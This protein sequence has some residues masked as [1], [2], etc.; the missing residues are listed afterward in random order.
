MIDIL[1]EKILD[2]LT[3]GFSDIEDLLDDINEKLSPE[4]TVDV[5][6][7]VTDDANSN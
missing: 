4:T 5:S 1:L 7:T 3:T 2:I 6:E